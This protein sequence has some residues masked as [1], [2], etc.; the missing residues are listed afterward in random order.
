MNTYQLFN[1]SAEMRVLLAHLDEVGG[2]LTPEIEERFNDLVADTEGGIAELALAVR[3][4]DGSAV[5]DER[6][7]DRFATRAR[8]KR[9]AIQT[10]R[11]CMA[12]HMAATDTPK[13]KTD[14]VTV[15]LSKGPETPVWD[16]KDENI[17]EAYKVVLTEYRV[18]REAVLRDHVDGV[19]LPEGM[20]I[21]R[22][23]FVRII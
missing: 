16:G 20:R 14:L 10:I 18:N 17:P 3:E 9:K 12:D 19:P 11:D 1:L 13:V 7:R 4:L 21:K 15:S 23:N 8:R 2:E 6:E 22:S 5:I